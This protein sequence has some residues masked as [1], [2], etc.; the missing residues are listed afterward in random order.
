M[1]VIDISQFNGAIDFNTYTSNTNIEGVI[2]R[3]GYRGYGSS[4]KLVEDKKF[5]A[6]MD[7]ATKAG[8]KVGVYFVS[9]AITEAEAKNE[10]EFVLE[11]IAIYATVLGVYFDSENGNNGKGRADYGKLTKT[12][13]SF[14]ARAFCS[15]IQEEGYIAG[16]YASQSW[17]NDCF[18][19]YDLKEYKKWVAKYSDNPPSIEYDAW[20][21]TSKGK[22]DIVSGNVDISVFNDSALEVKEETVKKSNEEV[23]QEVINGLWGNGTDRKTK[24]TNAGYDY[25]TIQELINKLVGS[26]TTTTTNNTATYYT[27]KR[28]D[29]LSAIA[30]KYKT[31][32]A[33]LQ[34]INGIKNPNKINI[35]QKIKVKE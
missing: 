13:R 20:Q 32:V 31:S 1:R 23:A 3:V 29:T 6:N 5:K 7:G 21:Y 26:T 25:K 10:A 9:Q 16:V 30:S 8:L 34:K 2:I 11:R 14:I 24:L 33:Y 12:Q 35:G 22:V 17:F 18:N 15:R 4:A 19:L 28:G 27:V